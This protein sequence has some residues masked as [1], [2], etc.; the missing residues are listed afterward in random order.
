MDEATVDHRPQAELEHATDSDSNAPRSEADGEISSAAAAGSD[1]LPTTV[2]ATSSVPL[3]HAV[4][5]ALAVGS[6]P[7]AVI[8][9][10][11]NAMR[12]LCPDRGVAVWYRRTDGTATVQ[13]A[14]IGAHLVMVTADPDSP[15]WERARTEERPNYAITF[16]PHPDDID[17]TSI[18]CIPSAE[19]TTAGD[20]MV[21]SV[22]TA[23][24]TEPTELVRVGMEHLT[25]LIG[26]S[27]DRKRLVTRI[28]RIES[29]QDRPDGPAPEVQ[30]GITPT[31]G[32]AD[33]L[34]DTAVLYLSISEIKDVEHIHGM[35]AAEELIAEVGHRLSQTVRPGD[36][37]ARLSETN[38]ALRCYG[39]TAIQAESIVTRVLNDLW[40]PVVTRWEETR[41][42]PRIGLTRAAEPTPLSRL[43]KLADGAMRRA[44]SVGRDWLWDTD[45]IERP[46]AALGPAPVGNGFGAGTA[47]DG[48]PG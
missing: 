23:D 21:V 20:L 47:A 37:I 13:A 46:P 43:L 48:Q 11:A 41:L 45:E 2:T 39:V 42:K 31:K 6:A 38:F 27:L 15:F 32:D 17:L 10:A 8:E 36:T 16:R 29:A 40:S 26:L 28:E 4:V 3:D 30:M 24:G 14:G 12:V 34:A 1:N 18:W 22:G 19:G 5:R 7:G 33:E 44:D 9:Q 25:R 35:K